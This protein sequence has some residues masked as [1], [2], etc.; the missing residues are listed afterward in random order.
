MVAGLQL[1][2]SHLTSPTV[3]TPETPSPGASSP[4]LSP[5]NLEESSSG[6]KASELGKKMLTPTHSEVQYKYM[7]ASELS[8]PTLP[9][10]EADFKAFKDRVSAMK[11]TA[12]HKGDLPS[13]GTPALLKS[14]A[15]KNRNY[16]SQIMR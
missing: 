10:T 16:L 1:M 12:K 15:L 5:L 13:P 14:K 3:G 6:T 7:E 8:A 2:F 4:Q 11:E 9:M